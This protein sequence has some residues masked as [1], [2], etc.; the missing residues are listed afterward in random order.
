MPIYEYTCT[1]CN[2]I[3]ESIHKVADMPQE[4]SC[5]ACGGSS[6]KILSLSSFSLGPG[7][8]GHD[9]KTARSR[10]KRSEEMGR[11]QLKTYGPKPGPKLTPNVEGEICKDWKDAKSLA[12]DLGK[13][14]STYD[15]MIEATK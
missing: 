3:Q 14:V 2:I 7:F 1:A 6:K 11:K 8:P 5:R 12:R 4:E 10:N 13:D 9:M 15:P